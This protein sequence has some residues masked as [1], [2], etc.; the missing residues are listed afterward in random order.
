M[1]YNDITKPVKR[2]LNVLV[3]NQLSGK[4]TNQV[5]S[6]DVFSNRIKLYNFFCAMGTC[7]AKKNGQ[8]FSR[9]LLTYKTFTEYIRD[10]EA[11][12][13]HVAGTGVF[14]GTYLVQIKAVH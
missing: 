4:G 11:H 7:Y 2:P 6:I 8:S 9:P 13:V 10:G 5:I 3:V 12:L 14:A 1:N